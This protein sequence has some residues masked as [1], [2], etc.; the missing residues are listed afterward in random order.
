MVTDCG[1]LD[2]ILL[3]HKVITNQVETAAAA[4]K[5][6]VDLDCS[7]LLQDDVMKAIDQKLLTHQEIDSALAAH[8]IVRSLNLGF[9][10]PRSM[11]P[12]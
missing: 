3:R 10:D 12:F 4:I 6:G 5:A 11:N 2:D 9:Y 7:N 1:A 8:F